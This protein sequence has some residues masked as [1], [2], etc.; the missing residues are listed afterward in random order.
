MLPNKIIDGGV[1]GNSMLVSTKTGW[2]LGLLIFCINAPF[3]LLAYKALG[4]KF[5][6]NTFIAI[7]LLSIATNIVTRFHH[8]TQD[9]LLATV[10]GGILLG[11]GVGLILRSNASLDGTEMVSIDL[12]KKLKIISVGALL[13]TINF[14]IYMAAGFI[15]NWE[16]ALYSI[17]T[18]YVASKVIDTVLEGLDKSKSIRI[19]S[20]KHH[21]IGDGIMKEL[22][23]SVTFFLFSS[24]TLTFT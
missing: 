23:V 10:F 18:Y 19:V 4:K 16:S 14:F 17:L 20:D 3:V 12:S 1:I 21:E 13:M 24:L 15:L 9:L 22:D 11:L 7:S 8:I 6:I 2:N 5:V